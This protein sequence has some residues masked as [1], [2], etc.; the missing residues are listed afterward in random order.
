MSVDSIAPGQTPGSGQGDYAAHKAQM[1]KA[2]NDAIGAHDTRPQDDKEL[3]K[4]KVGDFEHDDDAAY[5]AA[6]VMYR[7]ENF[8]EKGNKIQNPTGSAGN[9]KIDGFTKSREAKNGT[10]AGRLQ[11]FGKDGYSRLQA[12]KPPAPAPVVPEGPSPPAGTVRPE[13]GNSISPVG[14]KLTI[15]EQKDVQAQQEIDRQRGLGK[16]DVQIWFDAVKQSDLNIMG[17]LIRTPPQ[18]FNINA[19]SPQG[20]TALHMAVRSGNAVMVD[21][22]AGGGEG[23]GKADLTSLDRQGRTPLQL[24]ESLVEGSGGAT[25]YND[26]IDHLR[27]ATTDRAKVESQGG[28]PEEEPA[29]APAPEPEAEPEQTVGVPPKP[30]TKRAPDDTRS[31]KEI[32]DDPN[33]PGAKMLRELSDE[34]KKWLKDGYDWGDKGAPEGVKAFK[35]IGDYEADPDKAVLAVKLMEYFD[36][37][38]ANGDLTKPD[39]HV[40][41]WFKDGDGQRANPNTNAARFQD[42]CKYGFDNIPLGKGPNTGGLW[43]LWDQATT[44][45]KPKV[46]GAPGAKGSATADPAGNKKS[47]KTQAAKDNLK[48]LNTF[49]SKLEDRGYDEIIKSGNLPKGKDKADIIANPEKYTVEQ[50]AAAAAELL[51]AR[52]KVIRGADHY[53]DLPA[54]V[55]L[56]ENATEVAKDIEWS[57]SRIM[58]PGGEQSEVGALLNMETVKNMQKVTFDDP[59]LRK[60]MRDNLDAISK[61]GKFVKAALDTGEGDLNS[62]FDAFY[63]T[64]DNLNLAAGSNENPYIDNLTI[65][66]DTKELKDA[67]YTDKIFKEMDEKLLNDGALANLVKDGISDE[68][69]SMIERFQKMT[70][71]DP[72]R[73]QKLRDTVDAV[74]KDGN[75]VKDALDSGEGS[76][77]DKLAKFYDLVDGLNSMAG[78][79]GQPYLNNL[80]VNIFDNKDLV[81]GGYT[82]KVL[83]EMDETLLD[84][85]SL[86]KLVDGGM[87]EQEAAMDI[88]ARASLFMNY[89]VNP[90][91]ATNAV[92]SNIVH[93][94]LKSADGQ[95]LQ[96]TLTNEKDE[97]DLGRMGDIF[98]EF[99]KNNPD[100]P[101]LKGEGGVTTPDGVGLTKA[102]FI[103]YARN[104][105]DAVRTTG[106]WNSGTKEVPGKKPFLSEKNPLGQQ[107]SNG[108][109]HLISSILLAGIASA[110]ASGKPKDPAAIASTA[111]AFTGAVGQFGEA[112]LMGTR[113]KPGGKGL[114]VLERWKNRDIGYGKTTNTPEAHQQ[115][116]DASAAG[117]QSIVNKTD[118]ARGISASSSIAIMGALY[119]LGTKAAKEGRPAEAAILFGAGTAQA[120]SAPFAV[121]QSTQRRWA[122][123]AKSIN[124]TLKVYKPDSGRHVVNRIGEWGGNKN[125]IKK[126]V[127]MGGRIGLAANAASGIIFTGVVI[128]E[129]AKEEADKQKYLNGFKGTLS[130]YDITGNRL[131]KKVYTAEYLK[132]HP[133]VV[134]R[135]NEDPYNHLPDDKS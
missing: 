21:L 107:Y 11:D 73:R 38:E 119:A 60:E 18:G 118:I 120:A 34:H 12:N 75:L 59:R 101:M 99:V 122:G 14:L 88:N 94:G 113:Y 67:G 63:H 13:V 135:I 28:P 3:L 70:F 40:G 65:K 85:T 127:R 71:D 84:E 77:T 112:A 58:G 45:G 78:Q 79:D 80:T 87:S 129:Y 108:P 15:P 126:I 66:I 26:A 1:T 6:D 35:G 123:W 53:Q 86:A 72:A 48:A 114:D 42:F 36:K 27:T 100:S 104:F 74:A 33:S 30:D 131:E 128:Y 46:N 98:D 103:N 83:K 68:E 133:E 106:K 2:W 116:K 4:N 39:G 134:Q 23:Q 16:A 41:G 22:L 55:H 90:D 49:S 76:T 54:D 51:E 17:A 130:D 95:E 117:R 20:D 64:A 24:G 96:G 52:N 8:D 111:A 92:Q 7:I 5:R 62:R 81:D 82:D 37:Y 10:E 25:Y 69:A 125:N 32:L 47:E 91:I 132:E 93:Q 57:I 102:Q 43:E 109:F 89:G 61:D 9:G 31:A 29:P 56:N 110:R 50:R 19:I 44:S 105:W 115:L 121:I 124:K 97:L